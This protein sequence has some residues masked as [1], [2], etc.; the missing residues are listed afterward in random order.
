VSSRT[1]EQ[2]YE[3]HRSTLMASIAPI[4]AGVVAVVVLS[5][6]VANWIFHP[7]D[8]PRLLDF[9]AAQ[10][11]VPL[12]GYALARG[13]L[14]HH[15]QALALA[16]DLAIT[17][18]LALLLIRPTA[19]TSGTALF[20]SLK[21]L[22][23]ALFLP[24]QPRFQ[25]V[26]AAGT[27]VLYGIGLAVSGR[28]EEP[29]VALHQQVGPVIAAF[30]SIVGAHNAERVRASL[31]RR[32][33][34][35]RQSQRRLQQEVQVSTALANVSRDLIS[36][37]DTPALLDRLCRLTADTLHC[38][39]S[40]VFRWRTEGEVFEPVSQ[41]GFAPEEWE[42]LRLV[43]LPR[44]V[45]SAFL[46]HLEREDVVH[47]TT[48]GLEDPVLRGLATEYGVTRSLSAALRRGGTIFGTLSAGYRGR[49]PAFDP[50][51]DRTFRGIARIASLALESA[52]LV[53][54]LDGANR[55]KSE[56]VAT[57][58]HELRTPLNVI[59]G[60]SE[61][62]AGG[63]FGA[64]SEDQSDIIRRMQRAARTLLDLIDS[65]LDLSRLE[66]GRVVLE[67]QDVDVPS[68][69]EGIHGE[70]MDAR[71]NPAV[72]CIWR[73]EPSLPLLCTDPTKLK[74]IVKNLLTNALKFTDRGSVMLEAQRADGGVAIAV[75]DTGV[76]IP[77]AD[78]PYIFEP[79]RQAGDAA[80]RRA[81]GVGL[82]LHIAWRLV[83]A[84]GGTLSVDSVL[85]RGSTFRVWI[86]STAPPTRAG[87]H[88]KGRLSN[89]GG[90]P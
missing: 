18:M 80:A 13:P 22:A 43:R 50:E 64:L 3:A 44:T 59:L 7:A 12:I 61:L 28:V 32:G 55:A 37:L 89:G 29:V 81:G 83:N 11:A 39:F 75:T 78:L 68:L 24:W 35:L 26:S 1:L 45:M 70:M 74:V 58:S 67:L 63:E 56:F 36:A 34:A 87:A 51:Q 10:L 4:I 46:L 8:F 23:T 31:F 49:A 77:A 69:L 71:P 84:L 48:E 14:R 53:E 19:T 60:Y 40:H 72:Q 66:A 27:L 6:A 21:M 88:A 73:A 76:G 5:Y 86:P 42:S 57:M 20:L 82:G 25:Y 15:L 9:Y 2:R 90:A 85:G 65:T 17:L 30:F 16:A 54:E 41:Q 38:D 62:L 47:A 79:F 52:R 33:D